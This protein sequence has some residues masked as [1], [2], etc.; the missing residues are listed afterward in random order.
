MNRGMTYARLALLEER[1]ENR[2]GKVI[3]E[4]LNGASTR[5]GVVPWAAPPLPSRCLAVA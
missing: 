5:S 1:E 3:S 4:K 2:S